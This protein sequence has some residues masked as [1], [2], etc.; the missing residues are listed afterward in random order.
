MLEALRRGPLHLRALCGLALLACVQLGVLFHHGV[1]DDA[2]GNCQT[3]TV[4]EQTGDALPAGVLPP[5]LN[6][7]LLPPAQPAS[8]PATARVGTAYHARAPPGVDSRRS[9][10]RSLC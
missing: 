7:P 2:A 8:R 9:S 6:R 5:D 3:C 1:H 10:R 4:L